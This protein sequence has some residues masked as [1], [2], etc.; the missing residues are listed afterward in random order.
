[1]IKT[2]IKPGDQ[3]DH[4]R[5]DAVISSSG[6]TTVFRALDLRTK[7]PVA[8]KL[9]QPEMKNDPTF[10]ERFQRE[11]EI[12]RNLEHPGILKAVLDDR[13]SHMYHV[14][15]WFQGDT[16][17]QALAARVISKE[18]GI[19]IAIT[20]CN[21]LSHLHDHGIAHRNLKPE[22]ILVDSHDNVKLISF[23]AAGQVGAKRI[24]F[25]N[26]A[27]LV[28]MT[29]Y[30]PPEEIEGKRGDTRGDIYALGVILYEI[31]TGR[32]PYEGTT[33]R[34]WSTKSPT[35]PRAIDS[36][37]SPQLQEVIFRATESDPRQR[38]GNAH[39]LAYDLS[40][41]E[42]V[43]VAEREM[44]L[45]RRTTIAPRKRRLA[46]FLAIGLPPLLLFALLLYIARHS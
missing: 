10:L 38:Y 16:L 37:I 43:Q 29:A 14:T 27:Q 15:E 1:M 2:E 9:P 4:Y 44:I 17:R 36:E 40:H 12:E 6:A 30:I 19:R 13:R 28:G 35:P 31:L 45:R 25:A 7:M 23:G 46:L 3:L 11:E 34:E 22:N 20:I 32:T 24:T 5:I 39:K 26:V 42:S 21:V 18:R 41:L 8:I 33:I